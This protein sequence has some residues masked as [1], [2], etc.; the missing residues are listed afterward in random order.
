MEVDDDD[1][2]VD[3]EIIRD[4]NCCCVF[5]FSIGNMSSVSKIPV[6]APATT[7]ERKLFSGLVC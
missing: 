1:E 5:K 7:L 4:V 6:M 2:L 3:E